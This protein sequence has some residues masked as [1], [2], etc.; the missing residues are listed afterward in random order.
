MPALAGELVAET[1]EYD[2]GRQVTAYVPT[3]PPEA[4]VFAADGGW[5][6]AR[7]GEALE[8]SNT[9]PT[10]IVGVHGLPNDDGRLREYVAGRDPERFA[11]HERF[12]VDDV[13]AWL[14]SRFAVAL[15]AGRTAVWGASLGGE[16]ALALGLRHPD[17][18]G[19]VL[20][21]S[22]GAG[23]KPPAALPPSLPRCYLV[24]GT[25]EQ[26]FLDN[27][28]RWAGALR[29]AGAD[30]VMM[31]RDGSHGGAFWGQEFPLMVAWA[32]GR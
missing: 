7:L 30:V 24:A 14:E 13:R 19:A 17:S 29:D 32:F 11:A 12:F 31:E 22:P 3:Q 27:A 10:L 20:C 15:P 6:I 4:V 16:L 23:F 18:Y 1:L 21:A 8:H 9:P 26:F 2:G 25:Q 28:A 5:H